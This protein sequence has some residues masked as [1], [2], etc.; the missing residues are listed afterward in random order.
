M[1]NMKMNKIA[2]FYMTVA[3]VA[4]VFGLCSSSSYSQ[5]PANISDP[6]V[7][8][9][10][11]AEG[12]AIEG[13]RV[14]WEPHAHGAIN[15]TAVGNS[16]LANNTSGSANTACGVQALSNNNGSYPNGSFNTACGF[17]ALLSNTTGSSNTA[18]GVAALLDNTT[19]SN[20]T[21]MGDSTFYNSTTGSNNTALGFTACYNVVTG[22]NII[23]IGSGAGPASDI[24]GPATYIAGIYGAATTGAGNPLVCID[25][26]GLLGT[27]NCATSGQ[28]VIER[29]R[30]QIEV[31]QKQN[32]EFQRRLSR[33]ESLIAKK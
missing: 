10:N 7:N 16:A 24:P 11:A 13:E 9:Y 22:S 32:E 19:G 15:N 26:T 31:L 4:A 3:L 14:L 27:T 1:N 23:C 25:S 2:R 6:L 30:A 33:L 12:Y 21:G 17:Q 28:E 20:N 5:E 8:W 29:Q 18:S